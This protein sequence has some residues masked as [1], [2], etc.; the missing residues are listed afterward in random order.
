MNIFSEVCTDFKNSTYIHQAHR[1]HCR[2][3]MLNAH[4][5]RKIKTH[6]CQ[7][8]SC[9]SFSHRSPFTNTHVMLSKF[10]TVEF[11]LFMLFTCYWVFY[12]DRQNEIVIKRT[13]YYRIKEE[14]NLILIF[15]ILCMYLICR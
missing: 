6:G 1:S 7:Q 11:H 15:D 3:A 13:F 9:L 14:Q 2:F 8:F 5:K 10:L 12:E 4:H